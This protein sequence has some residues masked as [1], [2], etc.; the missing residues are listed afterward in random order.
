MCALSNHQVNQVNELIPERLNRHDLLLEFT[1]HARRMAPNHFR[2]PFARVSLFQEMLGLLQAL[3][4][5]LPDRH[6]VVHIGWP[7]SSWLDRLVIG[8]LF[9]N[10]MRLPRL[11]PGFEF[12]IR[13]RSKSQSHNRKPQLSPLPS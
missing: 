2:P 4:N 12:T 1:V 9:L 11:F 7:L 3:K 13:Y 6:A 5:E 10:M 8:V